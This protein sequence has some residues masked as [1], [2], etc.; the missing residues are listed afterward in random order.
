MKL[1]IH[2]SEIESI[3]YACAL[4]DITVTFAP[5]RFEGLFKATILHE[6]GEDISPALAWRLSAVADQKTIVDRNERHHISEK[7]LMP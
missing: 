2:I 5:T 3:K 7:E 4:S 6:N 1:D